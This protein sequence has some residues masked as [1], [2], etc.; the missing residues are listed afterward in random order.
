LGAFLPPLPPVG[1]APQREERVRESIAGEKNY[2][3]AAWERRPLKPNKQ[4][5]AYATLI[6]LHCLASKETKF[7]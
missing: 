4:N 3:T 5:V 1:N 7:L 2:V 6:H